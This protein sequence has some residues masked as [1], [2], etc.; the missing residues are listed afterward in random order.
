MAA[1]VGAARQAAAADGSA[2][3]PGGTS[4]SADGV[5]AGAA[6]GTA[7]KK[8][9]AK[10]PRT[11]NRKASS[12]RI[13]GRLASAAR[14]TADAALRVGRRSMEVA[15][16]AGQALLVAATGNWTKEQISEEAETDEG[17]DL[18]ARWRPGAVTGEELALPLQPV[19]V[20]GGTAPFYFVR[21]RDPPTS[22]SS[23][24]FWIAKNALHA[25][26]EVDF[27]DAL[28]SFLLDPQ[29]RRGTAGDHLRT[30]EFL[31]RAFLSCPGLLRLPTAVKGGRSTPGNNDPELPVLMLENMFSQFHKLRFM[32]V[33]LGKQT[34]VADW[35]GKSAFRAWRNQMVDAHTNSAI[36][37]YRLE[38]MEQEPQSEVEHLLQAHSSFV[39]TALLKPKRLRRMLFQSLDAAGFLNLLLETR[40]V[41]LVQEEEQAAAANDLL[42][43]KV[44]ESPAPERAEQSIG[45][46]DAGPPVLSSPSAVVVPTSARDAEESGAA[47]EPPVSSTEGVH[48]AIPPGSTA[49]NF[50]KIGAT[51]GTK[52]LV[53]G[54]NEKDFLSTDEEEELDAIEETDEQMHHPHSGFFPTK[55]RRVPGT[56]HALDDTDRPSDEEAADEESMYEPLDGEQD[57]TAWRASH[58]R[59]LYVERVLRR[60]L[61]QL[62]ETLRAVRRLPAPQQ[63][64]GSSV[65]LGFDLE[66]VSE[67][68]ILEDPVISNPRRDDAGIRVLV[69]I[70]DWG[71][72][73][74]NT[75]DVMNSLGAEDRESRLLYW[76][77][78]LQALARLCFELSRHYLHRFGHKN[79]L[80]IELVSLH[81]MVPEKVH[82]FAIL[83]L[84]Q[85]QAEGERC[86][87]N[88]LRFSASAT[89]TAATSTKKPAA[90]A[91]TVVVLQFH[92]CV[93]KRRV[94]FE[95]LK[96]ATDVSRFRA[97]D[98][99]LQFLTFED[100]ESADR[101][102]RKRP[103]EHTEMRGRVSSQLL[104]GKVSV[105]PTLGRK[106][107]FCFPEDH[108]NAIQDMRK[109][110]SRGTKKNA[111]EGEQS[112]VGDR[113]T[114]DLSKVVIGIDSTSQKVEQNATESSLAVPGV[115]GPQVAGDESGDDN[116]L[117]GGVSDHEEQ[118]ASDVELADQGQEPGQPGQADA[119]EEIEE[120]PADGASDAGLAASQASGAEEVEAPAV[121][122]A[123]DFEGEH[124]MMEPS[125][126]QIVASIVVSRKSPDEMNDS[127]A[128]L[129]GRLAA[130][131]PFATYL[132]EKLTAEEEDEDCA[133]FYKVLSAYRNK[134]RRLAG[135]AHKVPVDQTRK[136]LASR[137]NN[138]KN[139][140]AS[141]LV[142][143]VLLA[144]SSPD[145]DE[146]S[147]ESICSPASEM[148]TRSSTSP[149][150]H[151]VT[152]QSPW[153]T[154]LVEYCASSE[155]NLLPF[156][157]AEASTVPEASK[158]TL[159]VPVPETVV[160]VDVGMLQTKEIVLEQGSGPFEGNSKTTRSTYRTPLASAL[161]PSRPVQLLPGRNTPLCNNQADKSNAKSKTCS[162]EAIR[163][164]ENLSCKEILCEST[165]EPPLGRDLCRETA[166]KPQ[167][168][169]RRFLYYE[170]EGTTEEQQQRAT[171]GSSKNK[172]NIRKFEFVCIPRTSVVLEQLLGLDYA[173]VFA[174]FRRDTTQ[175][176][177]SGA[178][179]KPA[180]ADAA[181]QPGEYRA[182]GDREDDHEEYLSKIL[183]TPFLAP[184]SSLIK[185]AN[186]VSEKIVDF[187]D[188]F[189][190]HG[191]NP[192]PEYTH[193]QPVKTATRKKKGC[194]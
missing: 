188:G 73:E 191:L 85:L 170:T 89:S 171:T 157:I 162:S 106:Y 123:S 139:L 75:V 29:K 151:E 174:A 169:D 27:Y 164:V 160:E 133:I 143:A 70:F 5:S 136:V 149:F 184:D 96:L 41:E 99:Q 129:L 76:R 181:P 9:T 61:V 118:G 12:T 71:R 77:Y 21:Y 93:P 154:R 131:S 159:V 2:A 58:V 175:E 88:L 193:F 69:K 144:E 22:V 81:A 178:D 130:S 20:S 4:A 63:W 46:A 166:S 50:G 15:T 114:N 107:E 83:D 172:L 146:N 54:A 30:S 121:P 101:Y 153:R 138:N 165:K 43:N 177:S 24:N 135:P 183:P 13:D 39:T 62:M 98:Y 23:A 145:D 64:I 36:E 134:K 125:L 192:P 180:A 78:Y 100:R 72:S 119:A 90:S 47:V 42:T 49:G 102:A 31:H 51:G 111:A 155:E 32:D 97:A 112:A 1:N 35:K 117:T 6:A 11:Y 128:A 142:S 147:E 104:A 60:L 94:A 108:L 56:Q 87:V 26:D 45:N 140:L 126:T 84:S 44:D 152:H 74:F 37:G 16:T 14:K 82:R 95:V 110:A 167:I 38:G 55:R 7:T 156:E 163:V 168:S 137:G 86:E 103:D 176:T 53:Q 59:E 105:P 48:T 18:F 17:P 141:P 182:Q 189:L 116:L 113:S 57:G 187:P 65:G 148:Q 186:Y 91:D 124:S 79:F 173:D 8:K 194:C 33:K 150:L 161:P 3:K 40:D 127:N 67:R 190:F 158:N 68:A 52:T 122:G 179:K 120:N 80:L 92:T 10:P 115:V 25:M 34:A 19:T 132:H 28:R 185:K 66:G 109:S